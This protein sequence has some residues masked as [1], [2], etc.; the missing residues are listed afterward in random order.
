MPDGARSLRFSSA[1]PCLSSAENQSARRE[2]P[3]GRSQAFVSFFAEAEIAGRLGNVDIETVLEPLRTLDLIGMPMLSQFWTSS[4]SQAG[5]SGLELELRDASGAQIKSR[6]RSRERV[7]L[8][9]QG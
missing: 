1:E 5:I 4:A 7:A 3:S 2:M 8:L 6:P 9:C